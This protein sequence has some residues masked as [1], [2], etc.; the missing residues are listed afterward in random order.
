MELLGG[1]G[2]CTRGSR[3]GSR[4]RGSR[5][6]SRTCAP[7]LTSFGAPRA[8]VLTPLMPPFAPLLTPFHAYC[9]GLR[10]GDGKYRGNRRE[11]ESSSQSHQGNNLSARDHFRLG[12]CTHVKSPLDRMNPAKG[13]GTPMW[14]LRIDPHQQPDIEN[15]A[16]HRDGR[17]RSGRRRH[18]VRL[19]TPASRPQEGRTAPQSDRSQRNIFAPEIG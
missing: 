11:A 18:A 19:S 6:S 10:I 5:A 13:K 12:D 3:A 14:A 4:T 17:W 16:Q 7:L 2:S 15:P 8:A 1:A 9:L